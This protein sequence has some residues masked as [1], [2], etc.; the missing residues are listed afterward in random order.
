M[1]DD[2]EIN[3]L[4]NVYETLK[5]LNNAQIKRIMDWVTSKFD[6]DKQPGLKASEREVGPSLEPAP[7]PVPGEAA[8]P[9]VTPV[10]KRRG[11]KPGQKK[12]LVEEI[13][14]RPFAEGR[15]GFMKH[16]TFEDLFFSSNAKTITAKILLAAAYLQEKK[17]IKEFGSSDI[18][19]LLKKIRLRVPNISAS[20]NN[21]MQK[22]P[23]LLIQTGKLGDSKQAR[24]TYSVTEEG[25]RIARNYIND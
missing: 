22:K 3:A 1:I 16:D 5:G 14:P 15:T 10:K 19:T 23:P 12:L 7:L 9:T 20:I 21:L 24:R 18:N 4:A 17:K 8:E 6:L 25:L 11:R 2:P 13:Q